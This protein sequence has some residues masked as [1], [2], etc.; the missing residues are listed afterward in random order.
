M[1]RRRRNIKYD[2]L[3]TYQKMVRDWENRVKQGPPPS[4]QELNCFVET[5]GREFC[6][7][8]PDYNM[9]MSLESEPSFPQTF[10][11]AICVFYVFCLK[12]KEVAIWPAKSLHRKVQQMVS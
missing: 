3:S 8:P 5:I 2:S 12:M 1:K 10:G 9:L 7:L 6:R 4:V 11:E